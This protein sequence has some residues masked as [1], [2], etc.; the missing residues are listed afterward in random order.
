MND[1]RK[2]RIPRVLLLGC[3]RMGS[4]LL[5]RWLSKDLISLSDMLV[6]EPDS[7][8][9]KNI[10]RSRRPRQVCPNM[11]KKIHRHELKYL[12]VCFDAPREGST[13]MFVGCK[14]NHAF[15]KRRYIGAFRETIDVGL[16]DAV[17]VDTKWI[18]LRN[19]T[20][21]NS[22]LHTWSYKLAKAA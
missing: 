1:G 3:G 21:I 2:V 16:K 18:G 15:L 11:R 12:S 6:V 22:A 19:R 20:G 7:S 10:E 14:S 8:A 5:S 9:L 13:A 4:S 17:H